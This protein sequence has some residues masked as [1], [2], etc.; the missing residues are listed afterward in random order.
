MRV[1]LNERGVTVPERSTVLDVVRLADMALADPLMSGDA[2]C[3]DGRGIPCGP[4]QILTAGSILR[5]RRS[6]RRS[7]QET[8]ADP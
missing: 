7:D 2:A 8:H 5:V 1:F 3:T 6:A 4:E